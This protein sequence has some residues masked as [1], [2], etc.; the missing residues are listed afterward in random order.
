MTYYAPNPLAVRGLSRGKPTSAAGITAPRVGWAFRCRILSELSLR[1]NLGL[2]SAELSAIPR[3]RL[4]QGV[5]A[6]LF[7]RTDSLA[8]ANAASTL[9]RRVGS[10]SSFFS[11]F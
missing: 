6:A 1:P 9:L 5:A 4:L 11:S 2:G 8:F 10:N 7:D 3:K